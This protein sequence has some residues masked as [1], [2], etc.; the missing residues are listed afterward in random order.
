[1]PECDPVHLAPPTVHAERDRYDTNHGTGKSLKG[2]C[3]RP[4]DVFFLSCPR[5]LSNLLV[6]LLSQQRGW[7]DSG[8]HLHLAYLYALENFS[9]RVDAEAPPDKR[10]EYVRRLRASFAEMEAARAAAHRNGN[11][12]FLKSHCAQIWEPSALY[13]AT[14]GGEYAAEFTLSDE[15]P[16]FAR[17]L[18][19]NPTMLPDAYLLSFV[20]VFLIRHPALMVDSWWRTETRAGM[21]PDTSLSTR[22]LAHGLG[23]AR[24]LHDWYDA[25]HCPGGAGGTGVPIVV[26]ADDVLEGDAVHRLAS[27]VGMDPK[28]VLQSWEA[29]S[30][31][32]L[33]PIHKSYVQGIW[34]STG[35]DKSKSARRLDVRAKYKGWRETYGEETGEFMERL[36]ESYMPDY[37]YLKSRRM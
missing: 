19:T 18:R 9:T 23:L 22:V 14:K 10:R 32:G 26:D 29:K 8:Y 4:T 7:E 3:L 36:T 1:M 12:M 25:R 20:P 33:L 37:E 2:E 35:V 24:Q 21:P 27:T 28:Q 34:E 15:D 11:A 31:D 16:A 5:T 30:T 6:K 13:E 17:P